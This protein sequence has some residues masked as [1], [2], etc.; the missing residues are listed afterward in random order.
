MRELKIAY[1]KS[2][3]AYKWK[4][5]VTTWEELCGKLKRTTRTKETVA[6]YHAM[7]RS[8][9]AAIKDKGGFVGGHLKNGRR[10]VQNVECRSFLSLDADEAEPGFI[11]KFESGCEYAAAIYTTHGH[12]PEKPRVRIVIP[13][14]E[15]I[16]PEAYVAVARY[17]AAIWGIDQFDECSYRV[18]QLMYWPTTPSDGEYICR[19]VD[20]PF[21]DAMKFL[22]DYPDWRDYSKLPTSSRETEV[23]RHDGKMQEDPLTKENIV[24]TFCRTYD[25]H[26]VIRKFLSDIYAPSATVEGRYDYIPGE[27]TAGLVVY[28]DKFAYSH[29][30]TDPA[31]GKLLNAFDLVR[32]HKF[33]DADEMRSFNQMAALAESDPLVKETLE[34]EKTEQA[35]KDFEEV[36]SKWEEPLPFGRHEV[37]AFPV[38][39]LPPDIGNYVVELS[40]SVQTPVDMAGCGSLSVLATCSQGK[41][42]IRGKPDWEEPVNVYMTEV[43]LPSERKSAIEHAETRP[44]SRFEIKYNQVNAAAVETSKMERRILERRQKTIVDKMAKGNAD[45]SEADRIAMELA[46]YK[47]RKPLRLFVD[48]ITPEKL[49]SVLAENG[50]RMAILSSEAGIFDTLAGI[51]TKSVNIDVMLKSYSGDEIRVDRIGRESETIMHPALTILLMAQPNVISRVLGNNIFRGRGLTARFLYSMPKSTVGERKYRSKPVSAGTYEAYEQ[52]IFNM[53]E[54]EYGDEPEVITLS[55]EADRLLEEFSQEIEPKLVK[56]YAEIADWCGKLVGNTL[57]IA[58]LLCRAGTYRCHD[59]LDKPEPLVVDGKT[60]E[61]AIRLG[62]YFLNHAQA[63]F[64]VLPEDAMYQNAKRIL[65]MICEKHLKKFNRRTAMRYCQAFKTV[66]EIQPVLNFLEDYGYIAQVEV[67]SGGGKGRPPMPKYLV[68][69]WVEQH[70][71]HSV[72]DTVRKDV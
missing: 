40:E 2:S 63:V 64:N 22:E 50:G 68:N 11:G 14:A 12:V 62:R 49:A 26:D 17:Y 30:A 43:A 58:G 60:M 52:K 4:N 19:I 56:E 27:G 44:L 10:K 9:K 38:D 24:G 57:R 7:T 54:D 37:M 1:G 67:P 70:Y 72:M 47:E 21:M 25:I 59:F 18:N 13:F 36:N 3:N 23:R 39:A 41:Y 69:P 20:G 65:K 16:S 15:D 42:V 48:D 35:K 34:K 45:Q 5:D 31:C 55:A 61:N 28:D 53:L 51:Y 46:N 71:C 8:E 66:D 33:G 6:E 29:H 32:T